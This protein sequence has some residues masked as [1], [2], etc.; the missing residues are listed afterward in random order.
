MLGLCLVGDMEFQRLCL[1]FHAIVDKSLD[2]WA[3]ITNLTTA[4][5]DFSLA[6]SSGHKH[7]YQS[8]VVRHHG[9]TE[10][11]LISICLDR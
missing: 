4:D 5:T 2:V 3:F 6:R 8:V 7:T 1:T 10:I 9:N 11:K